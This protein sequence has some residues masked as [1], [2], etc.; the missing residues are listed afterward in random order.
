MIN[1]VPNTTSFLL[2]CLNVCAILQIMG[3]Q[4]VEMHHMTSRLKISTYFQVLLYSLVIDGVYQLHDEQYFHRLITVPV[5][6]LL[7]LEHP[8]ILI[9]I[10]VLTH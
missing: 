4:I 3:T 8:A 6:F 2:S 5:W 7:H 9:S 1:S 10:L